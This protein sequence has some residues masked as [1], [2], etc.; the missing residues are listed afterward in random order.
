VVPG[1]DGQKM[2]KSYGN[3]IEIFGDE[4]TTRKKIM[5]IV[6]DSRTPEEPKPDADKNLAIQLL[7]LVAPAEV[8]KDFENRL[9]A[10][11]LGYGDL[12]KALFEHCWNYFAE[13]RKK[14]AELAANPD[15][16]NKI[17][18]D[19]AAKARALAQQVLK[20]ARKAG[21]LDK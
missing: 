21:G 11:G 9:R 17:L 6:M 10:G 14:R 15:Y 13:A 3:T 7:K 4:K 5:S 1:T 8:A 20:R 19:G 16:V 2:S 18:A 12:K